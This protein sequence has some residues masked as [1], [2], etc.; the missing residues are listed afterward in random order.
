MEI[1][2]AHGVYELS[3]IE[4]PETIVTRLLIN[5]TAVN[6]Q[7]EIHC[8]DEVSTLILFVFSK[9]DAV[10]N[11]LPVTYNVLSTAVSYFNIQMNTLYIFQS[12]LD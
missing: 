7:T 2:N 10:I 1:L 3:T 11:A 12:L 5:D 8:S 9:S 6:N 4:T